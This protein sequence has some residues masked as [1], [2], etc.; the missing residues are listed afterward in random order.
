MR[1][2]RPSPTP[3]TRDAPEFD[4]AIGFI[5]A[6][7]AL[8]LTLLVTTLEVDDA[9]AWTSLDALADAVGAQFIA[10]AIAFVVIAG[11]WLRHHRLVASFAAIDTGLIVANLALV[12]A[13]VL[14]P[15][16][17]RSV[18][19]PGVED[20][21]LPTAVLAVNVAA[22]SI[23]HA[24]VFALAWRRGLLAS[25][26]EG[27]DPSDYLL[28]SLAPAAVFLASIPVA[29]LASPVAAQLC[30]LALIPV[31]WAVNR[32]IAARTRRP[33]P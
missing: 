3:W 25:N 7:F 20:L 29:Y 31:G 19:D 24:A 22:A 26:P 15:F 1:R 18:G 11:Y 9:S 5:D 10:F 8:A 30:W 13:I 32:R 23:L 6:T 14:L 12:A 27:A 17:T 2:V 16:S 33:V 4:R 28:A 21:P